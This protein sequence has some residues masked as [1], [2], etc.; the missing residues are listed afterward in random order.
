MSLEKLHWMLW[1]WM[2]NK[3]NHRHISSYLI[4]LYQWYSRN[5]F[6][7]QSDNGC[8]R[9][10]RI[11]ERKER[12]FGGSQG[13]APHKTFFI[14][15]RTGYEVRRQDGIQGRI[16]NDKWILADVDAMEN[17]QLSTQFLEGTGRSQIFYH[18]FVDY[19]IFSLFLECWAGSNDQLRAVQAKEH[20]RQR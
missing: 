1:L 15:W 3:S 17:K 12:Y 20:T 2:G 5:I 6:L 9:N 16:S 7:R 10:S 13:A 11:A 19:S 14:G 18:Y 4:N 8:R